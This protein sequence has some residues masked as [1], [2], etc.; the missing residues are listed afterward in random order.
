MIPLDEI[1]HKVALGESLE[2][3]F[4]FNDEIMAR[5]YNKAHQLFQEKSYH[6]SA[7]TFFFLS[8]INPYQSIYWLGLGMSDHLRQAYDSALFAYAMVS[9]IDP[10]NPIPHYHS[11]DC[12]LAKSDKQSALA[13]YKLAIELADG[14]FQYE[15]RKK[16]LLLTP[17][18]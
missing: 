5:F 16:M 17:I 15:I 7:D 13:S 9:L 1:K 18:L 12:Y 4:G 6:R 2:A 10:K 14:D 11:A 8:L 3:V